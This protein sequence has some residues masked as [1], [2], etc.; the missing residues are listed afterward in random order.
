MMP[1]G[2]YPDLT[3]VKRV[4]VIKLRHHGDVLLTTPMFSALKRALPEAVIDAYIYRDSLQVLEGHPAISSCLLYDKA[5]KSWSLL[6]RLANEVSLLMHI[7]RARYDLVI[8]LTEGD[9]GAIA[10]WISGARY[11]AGW[12]A[13]GQGLRFKNKMYTHIV[14]RARLPRHMVEQ[15]LD[16]VRR[17][18]IFPK[19]EERNLGFHIPDGAASSVQHLLEQADIVPGAFILIHPTSRWL[20][21]CWPVK[22][23]AQLVREL[24]ARGQRIVLSSGPDARELAMI[25]VIVRLCPGVPL[26]NLGGRL[27]LKEL[28]ALIGASRCLICVDSL[29]LHLA[30]ALK[31]PVVG[32]FGPSSDVAWGPW[33][34]PGG[35]V[36][37]QGV[38]CRPCNLDGCGGGK[39]SDCLETLPVAVVLETVMHLLDAQNEPGKIS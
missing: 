2:D 29:P 37:A 34:N 26:F 7:R 23:V 1:Y 21:K 13:Q 31:I 18:G 10:A 39:V 3:C 11:R 9:R 25:D 28:G 4:L 22:R 19:P 33:N 15:N 30:S 16:A 6:G 35:R 27:T 32:L 36:V 8:N 17:I 24:H 12:D 20:F 14:K 5:W 38:S